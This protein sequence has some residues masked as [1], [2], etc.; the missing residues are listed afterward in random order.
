MSRS[1]WILASSC[2]GDWDF[3]FLAIAV[4]SFLVLILGIA[5]AATCVT[6]PSKP[7]H[8]GKEV[9]YNEKRITENHINT[10]SFITGGAL[11]E[12]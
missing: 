9:R 12:I 8:F 6:A 5:K 4:S 2:G 1:S 7:V 3:L 10:Q 11:N